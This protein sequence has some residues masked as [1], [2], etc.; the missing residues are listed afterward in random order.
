M[1]DKPN[2]K[3]VEAKRQK[4]NERMRIYMRKYRKAH[5]RRGTK[6]TYDR[7]YYERHK[8]QIREYQRQYNKREDVR[9]RKNALERFKCKDPLYRK[10]KR[11]QHERA[12]AMMLIR[13]AKALGYTDSTINALVMDGEVLD[14][15]LRKAKI[16]LKK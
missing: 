1:K 16:F 10:K 2:L 6:H 12:S 5:S 7:E 8:W 15:Q 4:Y 3:Q 13:K 14:R 11:L 9:N